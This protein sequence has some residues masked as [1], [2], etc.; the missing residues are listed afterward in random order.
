MLKDVTNVFSQLETLMKDFSD[1][2]ADLAKYIVDSFSALS[3]AISNLPGINDDAL[4]DTI[5][6]KSKDKSEANSNKGS[7]TKYQKVDDEVLDIYN[8]ISDKLQTTT[9]NTT[10][11]TAYSIPATTTTNNNKSTNITFGDI[12]VNEVKNPNDFAKTIVSSLTNVM[13]QELYK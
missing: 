1:K 5:N 8:M 12:V 10:A 3:S 4:D 7:K 13:K 11:K 6:D 2:A 9:P